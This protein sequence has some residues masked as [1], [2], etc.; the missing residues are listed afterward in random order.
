MLVGDSQRHSLAP[1]TGHCDEP[2]SDVSP[3]ALIQCLNTDFE[4]IFFAS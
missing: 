1:D 2:V 3:P 4:H